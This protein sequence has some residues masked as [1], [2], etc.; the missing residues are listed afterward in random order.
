M[1]TVPTK[2]SLPEAHE[3]ITELE[4]A[5]KPFANLWR[6]RINMANDSRPIWEFDGT[7]ITVGH[8]WRAWVAIY[9]A[10]YADLETPPEGTP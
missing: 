6:A 2:Y 8:L 7:V 9:S 3:R 4:A 10:G 5:L 1:S